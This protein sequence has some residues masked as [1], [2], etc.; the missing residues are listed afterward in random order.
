[1]KNQNRVKAI[2]TGTVFIVF[3]LFMGGIMLFAYAIGD[4]DLKLG[5]FFA[6]PILLSIV[7]AVYIFKNPNKVDQGYAHYLKTDPDRINYS[8]EKAHTRHQKR[9]TDY[10]IKEPDLKSIVTNPL[11]ALD[12]NRLYK[13]MISSASEIGVSEEELISD[14]RLGEV[15]KSIFSLIC[16][17][18]KY[19]VYCDPIHGIQFVIG[20]DSV[21]R[22]YTVIE[23]EQEYHIN[24]FYIYLETEN[25]RYKMRCEDY[26]ENEILHY[27]LSISR[28]LHH[29]C[30]ISTLNY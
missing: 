29:D 23:E 10:C 22:I 18:N 7:M 28:N 2:L 6:V 30:E 4:L 25:L 24:Y 3:A 1:M 15:F 21:R 27:Y 16:I 26:M 11:F 14:V 8:R 19:T 17:G 5:V 13:K 12:G 20:N 9:H